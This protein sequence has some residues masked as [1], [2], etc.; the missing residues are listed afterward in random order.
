MSDPTQFIVSLPTAH[1]LLK[2]QGI[3]GVG[4]DS[5]TDN[6][7]S[8]HQYTDQYKRTYVTQHFDSIDSDFVSNKLNSIA[9]YSHSL[10]ISNIVRPAFMSTRKTQK[11]AYELVIF[12][13][14]TD[15]GELSL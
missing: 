3:I 14:T 7:C 8:L 4:Y 1:A 9:K 11:T 13:D 6:K 10:F 5:I 12:Y 15:L 2:H